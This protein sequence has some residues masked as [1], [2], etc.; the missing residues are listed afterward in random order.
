MPNNAERFLD[1][2][3]HTPEL[4]ELMDDNHKPRPMNLREM[5]RMHY[6][7]GH[8]DKLKM[9]EHLRRQGLVDKRRGF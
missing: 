2:F 7:G 1:R 8:Q 6:S 3:G 4:G 5:Q 9:L